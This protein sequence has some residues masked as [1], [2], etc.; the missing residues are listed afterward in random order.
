MG[1]LRG[2]NVEHPQGWEC[3]MGGHAEGRAPHLGSLLLKFL[4]GPFV[5]APAFVDEVPG[6]G[7]FPRVHMPNDDDVDVRLLLP[8]AG[9]LRGAGRGGRRWGG[10]WERSCLFGE[11]AGEEAGTSKEPPMTTP[12]QPIRG[13]SPPFSPPSRW[14]TCPIPAGGAWPRLAALP[15]LGRSQPTPGGGQPGYFWTPC[16]ASKSQR[17]AMFFG[18][19]PSTALLETP[20]VP[21]ATSSVPRRCPSSP[22]KP[23]SASRAATAA[24][25]VFPNLRASPPCC[26]CPGRSC[27][28]PSLPAALTTTVRVTTWCRQNGTDENNPRA[29]LQIEGLPQAQQRGLSLQEQGCFMIFCSRESG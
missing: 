24:F 2:I 13:G 8:H 12:C 10:L 1:H 25:S 21:R 27:G 6:G 20:P 17:E 16:T 7:G 5:N 19:L 11:A 18:V 9:G 26:G 4:N 23:S 29:G 14:T 28:C 3:G 22:E 15:V